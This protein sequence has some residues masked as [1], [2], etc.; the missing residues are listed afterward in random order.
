MNLPGQEIEL[1][2][3]KHDVN[4]YYFVLSATGYF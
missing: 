2:A 1:L 3:G 4:L